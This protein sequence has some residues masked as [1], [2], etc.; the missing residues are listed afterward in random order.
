MGVG[1][2]GTGTVAMD[3]SSYVPRFFVCQKKPFCPRVPF[4]AMQISLCVGFSLPPCGVCLLCGCP[5]GSFSNKPLS[6]KREHTKEYKCER[7]AR[8]PCGVREVR[9]DASLSPTNAT[10][11]GSK[12]RCSE[13]ALAN[14]RGARAPS[15]AKVLGQ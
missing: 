4:S 12:P 14:S 7:D 1:A 9:E 5:V 15:V 8:P 3:R 10:Q 6:P 11:R 2:G 13:I